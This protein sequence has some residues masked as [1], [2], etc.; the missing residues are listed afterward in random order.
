MRRAAGVVTVASI[1]VSLSFAARDTGGALASPARLG[2]AAQAV[3]EIGWA[4]VQ[5]A[6]MNRDGMN[7]VVW[8]NMTTNEMEVWLMRGTHVLARGPRLQPRRD[9]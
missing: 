6:D 7:E 9:D 4:A 5:L 1:V 2:V 8:Q 3:T